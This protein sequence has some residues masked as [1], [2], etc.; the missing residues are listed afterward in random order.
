MKKSVENWRSLFDERCRE[1]LIE[2]IRYYLPKESQ[3]FLP[4]DFG[5]QGAVYVRLSTGLSLTTRGPADVVCVDYP[6]LT[7]QDVLAACE[8]VGTKIANNAILSLSFPADGNDEAFDFVR[9]RAWLD[10]DMLDEIEEKGS[11]ATLWNNPLC[12]A[13][14]ICSAIDDGFMCKSPI[15]VKRLDIVEAFEVNGKHYMI[16]YVEK[17]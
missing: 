1:A 7:C 5:N 4:D 6:T 16:L 13:N 2:V 3:V 11:R 10:D 14:A 15:K 8:I 17:F 9:E 12:I